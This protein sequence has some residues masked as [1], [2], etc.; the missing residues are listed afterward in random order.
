MSPS[1]LK[2]NECV[3][4][5]KYKRKIGNIAYHRIYQSIERAFAQV[6]VCVGQHLYVFDIQTPNTLFAAHVD[7]QRITALSLLELKRKVYLNGTR[8]R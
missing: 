1:A 5:K 6:C 4:N 2:M 8:M 3:N 7:R